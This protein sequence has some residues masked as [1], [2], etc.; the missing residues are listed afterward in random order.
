MEEKLPTPW[1]TQV[2]I[3]FAYEC[4]VALITFG[5]M[6]YRITKNTPNAGDGYSKQVWKESQSALLQIVPIFV[7]K[8]FQTKASFQPMTTNKDVSRYLKCCF[9]GYEKFS[10]VDAYPF[11]KNLP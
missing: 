4:C 9:S 11:K 3:S 1:S 2:G 10:H 5:D 8:G 7:S 6:G